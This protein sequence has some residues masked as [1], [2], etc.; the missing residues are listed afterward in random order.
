MAEFSQMKMLE[1]WYS[2]MW[3]ETILEDIEDP[4][5]RQRVIKRIAKERTKS[6]AEEIFPKLAYSGEMPV[7]K[8][9][10][11]TIFHAEGHTPGEVH[12][13]VLDTINQ[14]R[15]TLPPSLQSLLDRYE[16]RDAAVKVVGVGS[17][18]TA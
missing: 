6:A 13:A 9:Q 12:A 14:Y 5:L 16:L 4:K 15:S 2:G 10:L 7:I 1:L 8:D 3:A 11:P 18:G 17:V